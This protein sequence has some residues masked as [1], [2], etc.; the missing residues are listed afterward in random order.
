MIKKIEPGEFSIQVLTNLTC[1]LNCSY[2]FEKYKQG[3]ND[4]DSIKRFIAAMVKANPNKKKFILE[5]V[6]GESFLYMEMLNEV[7]DFARDIAKK[8]TKCFIVNIS[9]NGTLLDRKNVRGYILKNKDIL[10]LGISLDGIK[11]NHDLCRRYTDGRGTYDDI[12]KNLSFVFETLGMNKVGCKATFTKETFARYYYDSMVHLIELGFRDI[13]G[14]IAFEEIVDLGFGVKVA[15]TF[16]R[17]ADYLLEHNLEDKVRLQHF[18]PNI[19]YIRTYNRNLMDTYL[20]KR[21][22]NE[23]NHCGSCNEMRCLG[24]DNK[25]YGCHRFVS[26]NREGMHI[27]YLVDDNIVISNPILMQEVEAQYKL[28]PVE[29]QSC[30]LRDTCPSCAVLPYETENIQNNLNEKHMCGWTYGLSLARFY[31][32]YRLYKKEKKD[33]QKQLE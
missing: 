3:V 28:R 23:R 7:T 4:A 19:D 24:L 20:R 9:T 2:C 18:Y 12:V 26:M 32:C 33:G 15:N 10:F 1:N 21:V 22:V 16:I 6:G 30:I 5:L 14:N 29:C 17:F 11:E 13:G 31:L 8:N 27:G 25:V